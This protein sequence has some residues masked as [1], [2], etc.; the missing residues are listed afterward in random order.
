MRAV[1]LTNDNGPDGRDE[2]VGACARPGREGPEGEGFDPPEGIG[3][4]GGPRIQGVYGPLDSA[5]FN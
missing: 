1:D 2:F 4:G 5:E 3:H